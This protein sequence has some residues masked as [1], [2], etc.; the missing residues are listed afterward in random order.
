MSEITKLDG[1]DMSTLSLK[2]HGTG[3]VLEYGEVKLALDTGVQGVTTLLSHSHTDHIGRLNRADQV[4]G[5]KGTFDTYSA[6]GGKLPANRIV[7]EYQQMTVLNGVN[8]TAIN[9]GHVLGST[10]FL[11]EFEDG[12]RALFTGDFNVVDSIV[13]ERARPVNADVLIT[14]ATYGSPSWIFPSRVETHEN[15]V[16]AAA[17]GIAEG[18]NPLFNAYS[19][20]K[21]QE[22]IALLQDRGISVISGNRSIDEVCKVY[23]RH[24]FDLKQIPITSENLSGLIERGCAFVTSSPRH[25]EQHIRRM[26]GKMESRTIMDRMR[27]YSL[28]GWTLGRFR[29]RGFPLSAHSDYL[30][31]LEFA[32]GVDPKVV[33]CFTENAREFSGHL[34]EAGL[35]AVPLE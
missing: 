4:I 5:T 28:S 35:N 34:A 26:L 18:F 15:I 24:G 7:V 9:A 1:Q 14:E 22:V 10:M 17:N 2:K 20:G 8:I 16:K 32:K 19:L 25:T 29:Q 3:I 21:A 31:L 27:P 13:H 6:R 30:G 23:N 11:I 12:L 33:Y